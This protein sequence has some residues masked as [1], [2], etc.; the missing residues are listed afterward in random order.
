M[1]EFLNTLLW[2]FVVFCGIVGAVMLVASFSPA[3][4]KA[5][6]KFEEDDKR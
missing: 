1:S 4:R 6:S 2:T 3:V 5:L